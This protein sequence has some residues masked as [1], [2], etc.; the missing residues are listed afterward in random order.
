MEQLLS[1]W[2]ATWQSLNRNFW[3]SF[4]DFQSLCF[5]SVST[6]K[7]CWTRVFRQSLA[8]YNTRW[9][10]KLPSDEDRAVFSWM[11]TSSLLAMSCLHYDYQAF[12]MLCCST[13]LHNMEFE[14]KV[15]RRLIWKHLLYFVDDKYGWSNLSVFTTELLLKTSRNHLWS[16]TWEWGSTDDGACMGTQMLGGLGACSPRAN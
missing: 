11:L 10:Q 6:V 5:S 3:R 8:D 7:N 4:M 14:F 2:L 12:A 1:D 9:V 16:E 15:F 13:Y